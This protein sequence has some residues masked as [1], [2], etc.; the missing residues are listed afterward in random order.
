VYKVALFE[1][2]GNYAYVKSYYYFGEIKTL[3]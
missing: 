3:N 2:D 1:L